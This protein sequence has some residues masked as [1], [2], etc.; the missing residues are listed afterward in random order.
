V[1][2]RLG[3]FQLV[4]CLLPGGSDSCVVDSGGFGSCVAYCRVGVTRV[5]STRVLAGT[6]GSPGVGYYHV[7][8]AGCWLLPCGGG[9]RRR[10]SSG[11]KYSLR[12]VARRRTSGPKYSLRGVARRT[13]EWPEELTEG[14][15]PKNSLVARRTH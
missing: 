6:E 3:W 2:C 13:H 7:E 5:L 15:G 9:E 10:R 12:G 8:D 1:C 11:P 14:C 4:C